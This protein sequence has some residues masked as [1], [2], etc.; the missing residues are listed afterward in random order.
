[1]KKVIYIIALLLGTTTMAQTITVNG[2]PMLVSDDI[3]FPFW[4]ESGSSIS[5]EVPV[6]SISVLEFNIVPNNNGND[7]VFNQVIS[8][9]SSAIVPEGKTWKVESV[10][11]ENQEFVVD[12]SNT[13]LDSAFVAAMIAEALGSDIN[14]SDLDITVSTF[15]D[16]LTI[17]GESVVVPG[18]S[19]ENVI[20]EFGSV[21]DI[22]GNTYQTI[23]YGNVE[24]MTENLDVTHYND[25]TL[26]TPNC[27][28]NQ[29]NYTCD[30]R[31]CYYNSDIQYSIDYGKLYVGYTIMNSA[32]ICPT[33]WHVSTKEDWATII[34]LFAINGDGFDYDLEWGTYGGSSGD[35]THLLEDGSNQSYLSLQK[36]GYNNWDGIGS[37]MGS[38]SSWLTPHENNSNSISGITLYVSSDGY[39]YLTPSGGSMYEFRYIRCVKD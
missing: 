30:P 16:T 8:V 6:S 1:M 32:N 27:E 33:G 38:M 17:N 3:S 34:D 19:F 23:S 13:S 5:P 26:I 7:M 22:D 21:T 2:T 11:M 31:W 4:L 14:N 15:G 12:S 24:W 25:G 39:Y 36:G 35:I 10:L 18:V 29:N 28:C 37:G 9:G 20:P